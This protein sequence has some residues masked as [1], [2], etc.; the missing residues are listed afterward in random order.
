MAARDKA[1][2]QRQRV[3]QE[4]R[5]ADTGTRGA[6]G[7]KKKQSPDQ[8]AAKDAR[9]SLERV[10]HITC[11]RSGSFTLRAA[12]NKPNVPYEPEWTLNFG[13]RGFVVADEETVKAVEQVINGEWSDGFVS[14]HD[15]Q[16][17]ARMAGL[18]IKTYGLES[19]PIPTFDT[20]SDDRAVAV[21]HEA[22]K[23]ANAD[24]VR[25]AIRYE[26]ESPQ[27]QPKRDARPVVIG[28]L[29]ALLALYE[30]KGSETAS[31]PAASRGGAAPATGLT[32]GAQE[33]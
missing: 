12:V 33:L 19:A 30:D 27:R 26:N 29:E 24:A 22:G 10:T 6:R 4:A 28:E 15:F 18:G 20:L 32:T 3:G 5:P 23:L 25:S 13:S 31:A 1:P 16:R 17:N 9:Q 2:A 11:S 7:A 21:A 8:L 14:A